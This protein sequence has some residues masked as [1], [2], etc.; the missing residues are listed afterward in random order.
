VFPLWWF[1]NLGI[2]GYRAGDVVYWS[3]AAA[4]VPNRA[5]RPARH[6]WPTLLL[7]AAIVLGFA[8]GL[9]YLPTTDGNPIL[10]RMYD[11]AA[12]AWLGLAG[13]FGW[14]VFL[15]RRSHGRSASDIKAR[16]EELS[17]S[18]GQSVAVGSLFGAWPRNTGAGSELLTALRVELAST[19]V[20][21]LADARDRRVA[22]FYVDKQH[23]QFDDPEH[24]PLRIVWHTLRQS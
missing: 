18:T 20:I 9:E 16:A 13:A 21:L 15:V 11:L 22:K 2:I 1:V 14:E 12:L 8:V 6:H 19:D 5:A 24:H 10:I 7:F 17:H 3:V 23:G 4:T